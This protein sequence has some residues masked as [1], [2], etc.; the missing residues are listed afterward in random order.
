M[1][2]APASLPDSLAR[3]P[4]ARTRPIPTVDAPKIVACW[5]VAGIAAL[6]SIPALRGGT[7]LGAT[8]PFWLVVAPAID[9]AWLLR[10]RL[11]AALRCA[12]S[13]RHATAMR[14]QAKRARFAQSASRFDRSSRK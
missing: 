9:L 4:R 12:W 1:F 5:L 11:A 7:A 3:R 6:V 8:V 10:A 13:S 2:V 14:R